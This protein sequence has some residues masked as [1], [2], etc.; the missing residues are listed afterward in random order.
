ML[1][2]R[3]DLSNISVICLLPRQPWLELHQ[4]QHGNPGAITLIKLPGLEPRA[5]DIPISIPSSAYLP[6]RLQ[7]EL[8]R[9]SDF[10]PP[11][12]KKHSLVTSLSP[13]GT[14]DC[15]CGYLG[16]VRGGDD[17]RKTLKT[18]RLG[19]LLLS[20]QW[21]LNSRRHRISKETTLECHYQL[22][23]NRV[24]SCFF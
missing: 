7:N 3:N 23:L 10:M 22:G 14:W 5:A 16:A 24:A 2:H 17:E 15:L 19:D 12:I 21:L 11:A 13:P 18:F 6:G 4:R 9:E 1:L 8:F 20:V